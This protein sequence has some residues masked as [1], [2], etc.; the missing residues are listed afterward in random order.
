MMKKTLSIIIA[1]SMLLSALLCGISA[2]AENE[3]IYAGETK[4]VSISAGETVTY[5]FVPEE[6]GIYVF[7]TTG[8]KDTHGKFT[9]SS[10]FTD[11]NSYDGK[12]FCIIRR[13]NAN[14]SCTISV[15]LADKTDSGTVTLNVFKTDVAS[16]ELEGGGISS[17]EYKNGTW[18]TSSVTG[19]RF[20]KYQLARISFSG[21]VLKLRDENGELLSSIRIKSFINNGGFCYFIDESA[22]KIDFLFAQEEQQYSE[23]WTAE[24]ENYLD[25]TYLDYFE[26]KLPVHINHNFTS[27]TVVDATCTQRGYTLRYCSACKKEYKT[28]YTEALGHDFGEWETYKSAT[29]AEEGI[30]RRYCSRCD[31]YEEKTTD[32]LGVN[33]TVTGSERGSVSGSVTTD[34]DTLSVTENLGYGDEYTLKANGEGFVGWSINGKII[35]QKPTLTGTAYTDITIEPI[36]SQFTNNTYAVYFYD[37]FGNL[38]KA[39]SSLDEKAFETLEVPNDANVTVPG[40]IFA[41]WSSE[42]RNYSKKEIQSRICSATYWATY[43]IDSSAPLFK[44]SSNAGDVTS[45]FGESVT[46]NAP[47]ENAEWVVEN[48][49]VGYGKSFD[50][51]VH[52][53]ARIDYRQRQTPE[54]PTVVITGKAFI[55]NNK[56]Q[57]NAMRYLPSEYELVDQGFVYARDAAEAEL[58]VENEGKT[59][60]GGYKIKVCHAKPG[61]TSYALQYSVGGGS[62]LVRAFITVKDSLGGV[63][64]VYSDTII[65]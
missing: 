64:T 48:T 44:I 15:D 5:R 42:G 10:S 50:V 3:T 26:M 31:K 53:D 40:Y 2:Y 39:Y 65:N 22:N 54:A 38:V 1:L 36:F 57:Y 8:S 34:T 29:A 20:Y 19:E 16:A 55:E 61:Y 17:T 43:K 49:V 28:D 56:W 47:Y 13:I 21:T 45:R 12:N 35:S 25:V 63:T 24:A 32:A 59:G 52:G 51:L 30:M 7:Y 4:T 37:R 6:S 14:T 58:T 11:N 23:A 41:G 9:G 46:L 27:E 62:A 18:T 33:I 60:E